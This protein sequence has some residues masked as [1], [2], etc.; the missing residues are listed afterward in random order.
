MYRIYWR[1]ERAALP[2]HKS[3][4]SQYEDLLKEHVSSETR[5]LDVGAGHQVLSSWRLAQENQLVKLSRLI[6]GF[7]CELEPL[8]KHRSIRLLCQGDLGSLPFEDNCFDLVT[9]NMVV[10]HL[11][12][13]DVQFREVFRILKGGGCFIFHTPN[14]L[15]Y[16]ALLARAAPETVKRRLIRLLDGRTQEDIFE[17]YYKANSRSAIMKL[18]M[19]CGFQIR[20]L[21]MLTGSAEL[22]VFPPL[23][24]LELVILKL[25]S[26]RRFQAYRTN[27]IAILKKP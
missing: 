4:E 23:A 20:K 3:P 10:E 17:T 12:Q 11:R 13:P 16:S 9:A 24:L 1:A 21:K 14:S 27:I 15:S 8:R 7:D 6:V 25:L 5:W 26:T 18:A 19:T 22:A 2:G